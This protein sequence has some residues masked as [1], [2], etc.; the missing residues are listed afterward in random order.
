MLEPLPGGR[1]VSMAART[2]LLG[3]FAAVAGGMDQAYFQGWI[4]PTGSPASD[5]QWHLYEA[6]GDGSTAFIYSRGAPLF[7][8]T[9]YLAPPN[10][11][12]LTSGGGTGECGDAQ[13][14]ELPVHPSA[15]T[16]CQRTTVE[17]CLTSKFGI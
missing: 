12:A 1:E 10:G 5:T 17:D 14:A 15:V 16:A 9:T 3:W 2:Q 7:T 6:V 11:L 4:S 13:F 8:R